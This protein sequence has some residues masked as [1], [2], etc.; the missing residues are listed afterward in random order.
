MSWLFRCRKDHLGDQGIILFGPK[1]LSSWLGCSLEPFGTRAVSLRSTH[2]IQDHQRQQIYS[3]VCLNENSIPM[4]IFVSCRFS[5]P[6]SR[7]KTRTHARCSPCLLWIAWEGF[8]TLSSGH[9][10]STH[11]NSTPA[12]EQ[13]F[14]LLSCIDRSDERPRTAAL[15]LSATSAALVL[16][17]K[18]C[19]V[20]SRHIYRICMHPV[21]MEIERIFGPC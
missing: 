13:L 19:C 12:T 10:A 5:A 14:L 15:V 7:A 8:S 11:K 3:F 6:N 17:A 16:G 1:L 21:D 2:C 20:R 9:R 4:S 18:H